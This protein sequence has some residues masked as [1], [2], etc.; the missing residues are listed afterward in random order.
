MHRT[1]RP[2]GLAGLTGEWGCGGDP[3]LILGEVHTGLLQ[4]S[5]SLPGTSCESILAF[6]RGEDVR[7]FQRPIACAESPALLTGVDC[8][9]PTASGARVR[10]VGTVLHRASVIGGHLVQG[11]ARARLVRGSAGRRLPWSYYL[12]RRGVVETIGK[13]NWDDVALGFTDGSAGGVGEPVLDLGAISRHMV[14]S[15]QAATLLDRTP[16]L[17]AG[18]TRLRW[19]A[20]I[21]DDGDAAAGELTFHIEGRQLRVVRLS[22]AP[23]Q[24]RSV[25]AFCEDLALHDWLLTTLD[26]VVERT[27]HGAGGQV[28][29]LD[30]L[31][32]A[33]VHLLH[34]WMPAAR[35]DDL[36]RRLWQSFEL[37]SGLRR[38]WRTMVARI[39]D[40]LAVSNIT[41][42]RERLGAAR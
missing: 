7:R 26:E 12:A 36:A 41:L 27:L 40:Q 25:A 20:V 8:R 10:A 5:H 23:S 29:R 21:D 11:S 19:V 39:R 14:D 2:N 18:R 6:L 34:L 16:P 1:V 28:D 31:Q 17:R 30:R 4:H 32:P 37:G 3:M 15:V 22:C 42:L 35:A 13:P 9:L 38:Q 24:T 33:I